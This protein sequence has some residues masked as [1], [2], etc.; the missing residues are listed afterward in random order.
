M[1]KKGVVALALCGFVT[2]CGA[3]SADEAA[4]PG[5]D[6]AATGQVS[7]AAPRQDAAGGE[8][9]GRPT[10]YWIEQISSGADAT[11]RT[12]AVAA[13]A[14]A[15]PEDEGVTEALIGA[16]ADP[17]ALVK[18]GA[19][20]TLAKFG[21][22]IAPALIAALRSSSDAAVRAG[23][24][25]ILGNWSDD[26]AVNA[27]LCEA[28]LDDEEVIV[29]TAAARGLT[30]GGSKS[31]AAVAAL[32]Q[33]L[34]DESAAVRQFTALALGRIGTAAAEAIPALEEAEQDTERMVANAARSALRQ[35]RQ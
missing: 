25:L 1:D 5:G 2:A 32:I 7:A 12:R 20:R 27:A 19:N 24:A 3:E 16:L 22:P 34:A 28:L 8:F 26:P 10:S 6:N 21:A 15:G 33:A 14:S 17:E 29:R 13:L 31:A 23:V 9:L 35:I 11:E 30:V 4:N 18:T